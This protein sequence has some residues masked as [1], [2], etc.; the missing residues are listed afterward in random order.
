MIPLAF[1]ATA[2]EPTRCAPAPSIRARVFRDGCLVA[3]LLASVLAAPSRAAERTYEYYQ[4]QVTDRVIYNGTFGSGEFAY[5]HMVSLEH[6]RGKYYA[7][8][9]AN[10]ATNREGQ[11]GQINVLSTS[12]DFIN[13]TQ[14]VDLAGPENSVVPVLAPDEVFWQPELLN[15][16]DEELICLWSYGKERDTKPSGRN[17]GNP[18]TGK[19]LYLSRLSAEPGAKWRH[20]KI[21]DLVTIEGKTFAPFASQNPFLCSTGRILAPLTLVHDARKPGVMDGGSSKDLIIMMNACAYSDDDGKTWKLSNP[22]SRVDDSFAQWEP[23]FWEEADG[24]IRGIMRNFDSP[25]NRNLPPVQRQLTVAGGS[26]QKGSELIF[27][28]EPQ[29][30]YLETGRTRSQVFR[31]E[32]GHRYVLLS[33]DAFTPQGA[34]NQLALYFSRTGK[35]DFVAGPRYSPRFVYATYSQGL[36]HDGKILA[37]YTTTENK[38]QVWRILAAEISPAPKDDTYYIWS[39]EK[40]I[41]QTE[42]A[43]YTPPPRLLKLDGRQALQFRMQG[44]A[45]VDLDRVDF[46]QGQEL[47][48]RL[49]VKVA[50][51]Q[52]KGHLVFCTFGDRAPIRLGMPS[53]RPGKLYA[54]GAKGWQLVG[55]LPIGEWTTLEITFGRD[56][57]EVSAGK[58]RKRFANPVR[59]P[60]SRLYLGNGYELDDHPTNQG[61]EFFVDVGSIRTSVR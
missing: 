15:I 32:N 1:F 23:H 17:W 42:G 46:A 49:Q 11:P 36:A 10:A 44:S 54:E 43:V 34:R 29:F 51:L 55:E 57:F 61:S 22:I 3:A 52:A 40:Y 31:S 21:M 28:E 9:G 6:F 30:A 59:S 56:E 20:E 25:P 48:V 47:L 58:T 37:A 24:T 35:M 2:F 41:E 27:R 19:G 8:W 33:G 60:T 13:W 50:Q 45:G 38:H 5:N 4:P 7:V 16:R 14:P 18:K 12:D 53:N 39:R 26:S